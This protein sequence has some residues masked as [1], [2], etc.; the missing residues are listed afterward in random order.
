MKIL[1]TSDWHIGRTLNEKSLLEDQEA[2]LTQLLTWL[3]RERPDI[4]LVAGDIYDRSVPSR[5]ALG[6]VDA[7]LSEIILRL[8]IPAATTT[9]VSG[10]P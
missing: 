2:L 10:W 9:V 3:D 5:E 8:G 7:V 1:H 4:L 6:L